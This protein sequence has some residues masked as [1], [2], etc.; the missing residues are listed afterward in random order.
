MSRHK[1]HP[2]SRVHCV[3]FNNEIDILIVPIFGDNYSYVI[4]DRLNNVAALVDPADP[5]RV[6]KVVSE[7]TRN[8][9]ITTVLSTHKH[10]DHAEGNHHIKKMIPAV[11]IVGPA[12]EKYEDHEMKPLF[13]RK[14]QHNDFIRIRKS[15][16]S[17]RVIHTPGHTKGHICYYLTAGD[18]NKAVFT[19]DML[20][21]AGVGRMFE[22]KP[23]DMLLSMQR[24][25]HLD[26]D[27]MIF[28]GHEYSL[29][30]LAFAKDVEP[31]NDF[32]KEKI[33]WCKMRLRQG[34]PTLPS[35]IGQEK[36]I[37]PFM[38]VGEPSVAAKVGLTNENLERVMRDLRLLK[39]GFK[40]P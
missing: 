35:S 1:T 31:Y 13:T 27:T 37:N 20:F 19:G 36:L 2:I 5:E 30:G 34:L 29:S 16:L 24:L 4:H 26:D 39:D 23:S 33:E 3:P 40:A 9:N 8:C 21:V 7:K 28:C 11:D 17:V 38:R 18:K 32:V 6:I 15:K 25:G 12:G 14:V 22:G 10:W